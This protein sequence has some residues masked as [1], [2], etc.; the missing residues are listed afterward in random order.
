MYLEGN[1]K[2]RK[3]IKNATNNTKKY[4]KVKAIHLNI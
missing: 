4:Q 1:R 2:I 3:K